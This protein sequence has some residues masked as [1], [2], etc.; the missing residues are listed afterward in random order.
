MEKNPNAVVTLHVSCRLYEIVILL[1]N[2]YQT[3]P[4]EIKFCKVVSS[5]CLVSSLASIGIIAYFINKGN[6]KRA[7]LNALNSM[8]LPPLY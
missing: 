4:A 1:I 3:L 8:V 6:T 7:H 5:L 2:N